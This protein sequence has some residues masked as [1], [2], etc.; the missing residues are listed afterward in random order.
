MAETLPGHRKIAVCHELTKKHESVLQCTLA[1]ALAYYQDN[2]PKGEFVF[3]LEGADIRE[4]EQK[5]RERWNEVPLNEH[6]EQYLSQG[7]G[8]NEAMRAV[9]KE[10]GMT[11]NQV[12]KE[13]HKNDW[14]K[15]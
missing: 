12:Y 11:K 4:L 14:K 10:R 15:L 9:A 3:V 2:E 13:L 8:R 6:L 7:M 5:E 1:E